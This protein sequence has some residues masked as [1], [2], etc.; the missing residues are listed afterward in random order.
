[1]AGEFIVYL[2]QMKC[3][4]AYFFTVIQYF[5]STPRIR[6]SAGAAAFIVTIVYLQAMNIPGDYPLPP[7][8]GE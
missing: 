3:R 8:S 2:T 7:I 1:M 4:R 5:M 6:S